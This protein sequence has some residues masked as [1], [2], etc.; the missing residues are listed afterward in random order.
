MSD[1]I[2]QQTPLDERYGLVGV[3]DLAE[4]ARRR[5]CPASSRCSAGQERGRAVQHSLRVDPRCWMRHLPD[6][7]APE[8]TQ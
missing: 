7:R 1:D 6:V 5:S 4:Y 3:R 8:V 2:T